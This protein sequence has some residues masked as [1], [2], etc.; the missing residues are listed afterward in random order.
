MNLSEL[1]IWVAVLGSICAAACALPGTV[2]VLRR[3]SMMSDAISHTVLPG[4]AI[5]FIITLSRDPLPMFFGA[6]VVGL[7]TAFAVQWVQKLGRMDAGA[8]M[9]VVFTSLFAVGLLLLSNDTLQNVDLDPGCVLYGNIDTAAANIVLS[10]TLLPRE[11]WTNGGVLLLNTLL[12][13]VFYKEFKLT[14][15]DPAL[16][17]SLGVSS[18][19]MHYLL[20]AM[21]AVTTVVAFETVGS[22]IVIAMFIVPAAAAYL[23]T[24]RFGLMLVFAVVFAVACAALGTLAATAVP[25]WFGYRE[26]VSAG[27]MATVAGLLFIAVWLTAPRHGLIS[28]HLGRVALNLRIL[29][30]DILGLLYRLEEMTDTA[31]DAPFAHTMRAVLSPSPI[32]ARL[33]LATLSRNRLIDRSGGAVRLTEPGRSRARKLVR[34]HRLW[35]TYL[36]RHID[37]PVSHVHGSA[38]KLEHVT[39]EQMQRQL[40]AETAQPTHDPHGK[41]VPPDSS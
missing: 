16:A 7:L 25:A 20:M 6:A 36:A 1:D 40:D 14:A 12:F 19:F 41:A 31:P 8:A 3:Q 18:R 32:A 24:D 28:K 27:A 30:E 22:V 38:E 34:T 26:T 33:A 37:I 4:L 13:V 23:L 9:G 29:R 10:D 2:L 15:F 5:A 21:T 35:E 17:D 39:S 11:I